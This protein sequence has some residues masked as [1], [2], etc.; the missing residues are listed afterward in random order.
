VSYGHSQFTQLLDYESTGSG[1]AFS[2]HKTYNPPNITV[3]IQSETLANALSYL[4]IGVSR[5]YNILPFFKYFAGIHTWFMDQTRLAGQFESHWPRYFRELKLF[6][7]HFLLDYAIFH[8]AE[9]ILPGSVSPAIRGRM[10]SGKSLLDLDHL[11]RAFDQPE[12]R[13]A[14]KYTLPNALKLNDFLIISRVTG[15]FRQVVD[16]FGRLNDNRDHSKGQTPEEDGPPWQLVLSVRKYFHDNFLILR[17]NQTN[18][19]YSDRKPKELSRLRIPT[20]PR[21]S[22]KAG[23]QVIRGVLRGHI[24]QTVEQVIFCIMTADAIR[25]NAKNVSCTKEAYVPHVHHK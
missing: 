7:V 25:T 9:K 21:N 2:V 6:V 5:T 16:S 11:E 1:P 22:W 13:T 20:D 4:G 14:P 23:V 18:T 3:C 15:L 19:T 8:D 24:P 10:Q 17:Y 12:R